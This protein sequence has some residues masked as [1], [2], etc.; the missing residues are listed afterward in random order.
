MLKELCAECGSNETEII[1]RNKKKTGFTCT[2]LLICHYCEKSGLESD[3]KST[4]TSKCIEIAKTE[5][6][7]INLRMTLFYF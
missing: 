3:K 4:S 7:D 6:Q 5:V 2:L 1:L